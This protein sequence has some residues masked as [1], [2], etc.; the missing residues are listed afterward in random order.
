MTARQTFCRRSL[1][2]SAGL[3]VVVAVVVAVAVIPQV[4]AEASR[5]GTPQMAVTAF[6]INIGFALLSALGLF[7]VAIGS[8]A[9]NRASRPLLILVGLVVLFLGIA[10]VDAAFAYMSHGPAMRTATRL[11]FICGAVDF[12]VGIMAIVA[13]FL[14]PMKT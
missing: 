11:L 10:C 9:A 7:L 2:T 4:G 8:K 6:G 3:L 13:A 1:F 12:F 14:L 5:G